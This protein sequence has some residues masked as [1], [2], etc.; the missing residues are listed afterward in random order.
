MCLIG[1]QHKTGTSFVFF[2]FY[3]HS[4]TESHVACGNCGLNFDKHNMFMHLFN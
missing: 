4:E 2:M 3:N 1:L